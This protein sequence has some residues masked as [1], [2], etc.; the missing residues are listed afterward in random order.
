LAPEA[1]GRAARRDAAVQRALAADSNR[2][3][4]AFWHSGA[5][6]RAM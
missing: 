1:D 6:R 3:S 4:R 2:A 5:P